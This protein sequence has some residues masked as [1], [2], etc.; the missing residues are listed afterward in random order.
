MIGNVISVRCCHI[1]FQL[2]FVILWITPT[3]CIDIRFPSLC[4]YSQRWIHCIRKR[5]VFPRCDHGRSYSFTCHIQLSSVFLLY[6][7]CTVSQGFQ[8]CRKLKFFQILR[9]VKCLFSNFQNFWYIQCCQRITLIKCLCLN[10]FHMIQIQLFNLFS[11]VESPILNFYSIRNRN[12][13]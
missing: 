10:F 3:L 9:A 2:P 5:I 4:R 8:C 11:I 13:Y 6:S 12:R 1:F 7:K